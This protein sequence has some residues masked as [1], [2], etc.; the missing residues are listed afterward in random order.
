M[1]TTIQRPQ[2]PTGAFIGASWA[3][4]FVG[5]AAYLAGLWNAQMQLNEKG[6]YFIVL[7]YGLFAAVSLQKTVRDRL[8][9]IAVTGIYYGLCWISL[10]L[11]VLLLAVGLWNA[12]LGSS[13][14]G[15]YAMAFLLSLFAAVAVQKNVR[16]VALHR[17]A[18]ADEAGGSSEA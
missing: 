7:M 12:T 3:A 15:F 11:A 18:A 10:L 8:D 9:G 17:P 5:G 2:R 1:Q 6:Y 14:K 4:L 13:E 16:D